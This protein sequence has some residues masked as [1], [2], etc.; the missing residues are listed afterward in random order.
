MLKRALAIAAVVGAGLALPASAY[1]TD[2]Y[3]PEEA[4]LTCS[5][6]QVE[7]TGAF[8]CTVTGTEGA[9]AVLEATFDN[10]TVT[11]AGTTTSAPK[12]ISGGEANFDLTAPDVT[13]T[14]YITATVDG[15]EAEAQA[16]VDVVDELSGTGF[17]GMPLAVGAGVLLLAGGVIV[18]AATRRR[19]HADAN[20]S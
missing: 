1:A 19:S 7:V 10:G 8:T 5:T 18:F 17:D 6:S 15:V 12:T 20:A 3:P 9:D 16:S 2:G 13:G 4:D 11:I 14:I